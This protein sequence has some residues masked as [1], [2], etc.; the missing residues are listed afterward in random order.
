MNLD[1]FNG[2]V[3]ESVTDQNDEGAAWAIQFEGGGALYVFDANYDMPTGLEGSQL[4]RVTMDEDMTSVFFGVPGNADASRVN[5]NPMNY[6]IKDTTFTKGELVY[7]QRPSVAKSLA[8]EEYEAR[9]AEGREVATKMREIDGAA[10]GAA[11]AV[12]EDDGA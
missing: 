4:T 1:Y 2:R 6:A 5:L 11:K 12:E 7:P 3:I 8:M 9:I 10:G